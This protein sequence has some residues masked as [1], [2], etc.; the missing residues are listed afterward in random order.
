MQGTRIRAG[1]THNVNR[2]VYQETWCFY[3]AQHSI[4]VPSETTKS[5]II[6]YNYCIHTE[7]QNLVESCVTQKM[8]DKQL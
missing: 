2:V 3:I 5:A 7:D 6:K 8:I 4:L 1:A